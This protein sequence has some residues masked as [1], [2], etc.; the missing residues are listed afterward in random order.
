M[1]CRK[2]QSLISAYV[3]SELPGVEMLAVRQHLSDCAE[4]NSEFEALLRIKRAYGRLSP[5]IPSPALTLRIYQ[6]LDQLSHP[7]HE[8]VVASPK[9]RFTFFPGRLRFA[10]ASVAMFAALLTL[11]SGQIYRDSYAFLPLPP[12]TQV[13]ALA[14]GEPVR[15]FPSTASVEGA[16]SVTVL[17][18][19]PSAEP[20]AG[21]GESGETTHLTGQTN[22]LLNYS[23]PR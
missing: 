19:A 8:Q 7:H 20:W 11:R 21:S 4:C 12:T 1:N 3:D 22:M 9:K 2:V 17:V 18:P 23:T 15:M 14:Q 13:T 10:A 16:P 6:E 5:G